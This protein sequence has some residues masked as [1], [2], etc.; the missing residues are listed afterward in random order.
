MMTP[1]EPRVK[2]EMAR[3][4]W[5][6]ADLGRRLGVTRAAVSLV[7]LGRRISPY[8]QHAIAR[9]LGVSALDE[10]ALWG[11]LYW[12]HHSPIGKGNAA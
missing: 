9:E 4:G 8:L 1:G 2:Q 3:R 12:W 10:P 6:Q 11:R 7:V 5:N